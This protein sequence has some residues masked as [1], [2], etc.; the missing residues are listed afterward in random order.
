[1][2]ISCPNCSNENAYFDGVQYVCPDCDFEWGNDSR[3]EDFQEDYFEEKYYHCF[4]NV[5]RKVKYS[6]SYGHIS[7]IKNMIIVP[8]AKDLELY[9]Q[10]I[11]LNADFVEAKY[12]EHYQKII[13]MNLIELEDSIKD[14][15]YN[16]ISKFIQNTRTGPRNSFFE[17]LNSDVRYYD[18][19]KVE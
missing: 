17:Y 7:D 6:C 5:K 14:L 18:L 10:Y 11:L 9:T 1:M 3:N 8:L 12:P 2:E 13:S 19:K 16:D 4:V 15:K